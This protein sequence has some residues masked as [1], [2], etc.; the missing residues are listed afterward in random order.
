MYSVAVV[1]GTRPE[2][3]K[4]SS[5]I[6][7]LR[8]QQRFRMHLIHTGQHYDWNM[9]RVFLDE[10]DLPEPEVFLGVGSGTPPQ[11]VART[12][13]TL[14]AALSGKKISGLMVL[15][16]TNSAMAAALTASKLRIPVAHVEAGCRSFD[17]T[18][19][20]ELNRRLISQCAA[21]YFTP[22]ENCT[23]N[24][25]REGFPNSRVIFTGHPILEVI[26]GVQERI[27]GNRTC[28]RLGVEP[29][30]YI[31]ATLHREENVDNRERLHALI[32]SLAGIH[33]RIVFPI[34]PRTRRRLREFKLERFMH[35]RNF[36]TTPPMA[37]VDTLAMIKNAAC[38]I[39][40][41][42]GVQQEAMILG[43]PTLTARRTTEWIE[44]VLTGANILVGTNRRRIIHNSNRIL[45]DVS[46][47]KRKLRTLRNPFG[48]G[49]AT[50]RI[51]RAL[52]IALSAW[53]A[54]KSTENTYPWLPVPASAKRVE[55][56]PIRRAVQFPPYVNMVFDVNNR[57]HRVRAKNEITPTI[58]IFGPQPLIR[59]FKP[60]I[61]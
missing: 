53:C 18:M 14:D 29:N 23:L 4:L 32:T 24:L 13:T 42:G 40:D 50:D 37:Y 16:D 15:G 22:T 31:F 43:T 1:V 33:S 38:V 9:S 41:S 61:I 8:K 3:I 21:L 36:I 35:E 45:R 20:E 39:T 48:D 34:H 10:F 58:G 51:V 7:V 12:V 2:I 44:T 26:K 46:T 6:K 60:R 17:L 55:L 56:L 25:L 52:E 47:L 27:R 59:R 54:R 49:R 57:L 28:A 11:Q 19:Q 30:Q 5:I